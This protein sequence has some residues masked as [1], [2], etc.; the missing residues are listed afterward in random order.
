MDNRANN[1]F[2]NGKDN[3]LYTAPC[4]YVYSTRW[5]GLIKPLDNEPWS[6]AAKTDMPCTKNSLHFSS[7]PGDNPIAVNYY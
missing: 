4:F 2:S 6:H 5:H 7:L 3:I 1:K